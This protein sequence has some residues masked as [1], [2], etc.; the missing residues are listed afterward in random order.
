MSLH[1]TILRGNFKALGKKK[2]ARVL[3]Q[4]LR[5]QL[6]LEPRS[7]DSGLYSVNPKGAPKICEGLLASAQGCCLQVEGSL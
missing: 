3:L 4:P 7:P 5:G 2:L 6:R 1:S